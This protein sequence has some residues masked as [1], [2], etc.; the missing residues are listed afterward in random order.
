MQCPPSAACELQWHQHD[1]RAVTSIVITAATT[2]RSCI[3]VIVGS[4]SMWSPTK[5]LQS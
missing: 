1:R 5:A 3:W 4:Y 2:M